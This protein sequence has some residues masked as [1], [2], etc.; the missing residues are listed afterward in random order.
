MMQDQNCTRFS[1]I[2]IFTQRVEIIATYCERR[3]CADQR[4]AGFIRTCGY[5]PV[6]IPNQPDMAENFAA[7]MNPAGVVLTGGNDLVGYGGNAPERDETERVLV[8]WAIKHEVPVYGFCRGMQVIL[9]YFGCGLVKIDGH[10]RS[11]HEIKGKINRVVNSYHT[12]T[13]G[14]INESKIEILATSEDGAIEAIKVKGKSVTGT[15]WH[16]ERETPF[17]DE[18]I[19][20]IKELFK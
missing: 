14:A 16:P 20:M 19:G 8:G 11:R 4:V 13:C 3:D 9:D 18:D 12:F 15:M 5:I 17:A 7:T 10:V 6:P 2:V 1:R